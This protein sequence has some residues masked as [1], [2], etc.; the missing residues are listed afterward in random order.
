MIL[1]F[2]EIEMETVAKRKLE[3]FLTLLGGVS[4]SAAGYLSLDI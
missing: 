4:H 1:E 3:I 2:E